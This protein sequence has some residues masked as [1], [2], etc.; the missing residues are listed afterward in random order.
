MDPLAAVQK[1]FEAWNRRDAGAIVATFAT[2]GIYS[3][4]VTGEIAGQ[5]IGN[6]A[7]ELFT[8]FPDLSFELTSLAGPMADHTVTTQWFMRGTN[9]GAFRGMAPT[10]KSICVPGADFI[11]VTDGR[12]NS[13]HG[14]FDSYAVPKQL[15][16]QVIVQPHAMGPVTFG[17]SAALQGRKPG[18]P[19]AFS[20]TS[21]QARSDQEA[22]QVRNYSRKIY[23]DV[24]GM[25]GFI[26]MLSAGVG[27]RF[28][29][30]AAWENAEHPRQLYQ[31]S[32]HQEAMNSFY[33]SD[34]S[35]GG[36]FSVWVPAHIGPQF[37]RCI[38]CKRMCDY[39]KTA[40]KCTCGVE[41]PTP[42]PY[43]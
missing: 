30:A 16:L 33:N 23:G 18:K 41:L 22:E 36:S 40:G 39:E 9:T 43:W 3:D 2:D 6:Y 37:V 4:P 13:V 8:G 21:L 5:A 15:G 14:H 7:T 34:F 42:P 24:A 20:L 17:Y 26:S 31:S 27:H 35:A 28:Y 38:A 1:Y 19:G 32:A 29:T 11:V 12:I 10:G 25:P